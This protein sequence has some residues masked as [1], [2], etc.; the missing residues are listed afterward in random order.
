MEVTF[1]PSR[2]ARLTAPGAATISGSAA[3]S[4]SVT[5]CGSLDREPCR[6]STCR[7]P[8]R[9]TARMYPSRLWPTTF[10]SRVRCAS[11]RLVSAQLGAFPAAPPPSPDCPS[12]CGC[13]ASM[14]SWLL[15]DHPQR[16]DHCRIGIT[17]VGD[18]VR[19]LHR[20]RFSIRSEVGAIGHSF[21]AT[22]HHLWVYPQ[23]LRQFLLQTRIQLT[24]ST[25]FPKPLRTPEGRLHL[26]RKGIIHQAQPGVPNQPPLLLT[27]PAGIGLEPFIA[28]GASS[29]NMPTPTAE[30]ASFRSLE[31]HC[32]RQATYPKES[33]FE[34][35]SSF[36]RQLHC[37]SLAWRSARRSRPAHFFDSLL[38]EDFS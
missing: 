10:S 38:P 31:Y 7:T 32:R 34:P 6:L 14:R 24:V 13:E 11:G 20:L 19:A 36:T 12:R 21:L 28:C 1:F 30:N 18:G 15:R 2:G 8:E 5:G 35:N 9:S 4:A 23:R 17:S 25:Q 27:Q 37:T 29:M 16:M 26:P 22:F 33:W 3:R